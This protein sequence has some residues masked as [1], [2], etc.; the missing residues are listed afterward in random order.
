VKLPAV[1]T[2]DGVLKRL[3]QLQKELPGTPQAN[4]EPFNAAYLEVTRTI[5][6]ALVAGYFNNPDF[7][8]DFTVRFARYYF[9]AIDDLKA[10]RRTVPAWKQIILGERS[11]SFSL[12][13]GANAHINYDL[14]LALKE[15]LAS[16][17]ANGWLGDLRRIDKLLMQS[18]HQILHSYHETGSV[19]NFLQRYFAWL[20]F[21]PTMYRILWWRIVAW[22][23]Y[24]RLA[25][26]KLTQTQLAKRSTRIGRHLSWFNVLQ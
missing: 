24:R 19:M 18:G 7:I 1:K 26:G 15:T 20:Y 13:M 14:P 22:R 9:E 23:N 4:L 3:N 11:L 2:V 12:L 8:T 25:S 10:K 16:R 5:N 17:P 21:R 6:D